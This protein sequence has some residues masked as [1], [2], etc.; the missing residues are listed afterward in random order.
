M[1]KTYLV[2]FL[3][4]PKALISK[5]FYVQHFYFDGTLYFN[6]LFTFNLFIFVLYSKEKKVNKIKRV[7][8]RYL[9]YNY[10][11]LPPYLRYLFWL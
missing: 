8:I 5:I 9:L 6:G 10:L 1:N 2:I 4:L 11:N 3:I 7:V